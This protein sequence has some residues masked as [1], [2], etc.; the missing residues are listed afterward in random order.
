MPHP[1]DRFQ[2]AVRGADAGANQQAAEMPPVGCSTTPIAGNAEGLSG[3]QPPHPTDVRA[4][5]GPPRQ[6]SLNVSSRDSARPASTSV[7]DRNDLGA[8]APAVGGLER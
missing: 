4:G 2:R 6:A 7:A 8:G 1:A 3:R 5:G